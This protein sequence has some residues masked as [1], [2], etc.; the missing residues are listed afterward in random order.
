MKAHCLFE[1]SGT[2]KNEFKKLGIDAY[3]YDILNDYGETDFQ[4]DLFA[5]IRGGYDGKPSIFDKI[6]P[7]DMILAFF[8]CTRF[9]DQ[10]LLAFRGDNYGSTATT[11]EKIQRSMKLHCELHKNYILISE[12]ALIALERGL[13]MVIENPYSDQHYLKRYWSLKPKIIDAD[14]RDNGDYFKKPTQYFFLNY[15]PKSNF[16]LESIPYNAVDARFPL[17]TMRK[18]VMNKVGAKDRQVARSMIHPDY[19]NRFIRQYILDESEIEK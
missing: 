9:E 3:D 16:L 13:Q 18:D 17:R 5:E 6:S 15:E 4:I 2:F 11:S 8:P 1:Q 7:D 10:I 14:R 12:L 19:A